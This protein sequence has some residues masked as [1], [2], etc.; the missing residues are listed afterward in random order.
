MIE[1]NSET[2]TYHVPK[3]TK[4]AILTSQLRKKVKKRL[5]ILVSKINYGINRSVQKVRKIKSVW[6]NFH[7]RET[8]TL[9]C[10]TEK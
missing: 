5:I 4:Y 9:K 10:F 3:S 8:N 6:S 7:K 2:Q 1:N